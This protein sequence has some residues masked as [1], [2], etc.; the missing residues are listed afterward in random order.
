MVAVCVCALFSHRLPSVLG[1]RAPYL[2]SLQRYSEDSVC[3]QAADLL[4]GHM[5]LGCLLRESSVHSCPVVVWD[6]EDGGFKIR[7]GRLVRLSPGH[8]RVANATI[9]PQ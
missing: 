5:D 3:S 9:C 1:S 7:H 2:R 6:G 8:F 4:V